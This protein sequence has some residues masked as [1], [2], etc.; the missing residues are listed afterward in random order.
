MNLDTA[1]SVI[2]AFATLLELTGQAKVSVDRGSWYVATFVPLGRV[3]DREVS[4]AV[5]TSGPPM[6][7]VAP[8]EN[9]EIVH[10]LVEGTSSIEM[11]PH[12]LSRA[13]AWSRTMKRNRSRKRS[14]RR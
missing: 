8:V 14:S 11:L 4:L 7:T 12:L 1:N 6:F 5:D 10:D 9:D 2:D 13:F 3:G